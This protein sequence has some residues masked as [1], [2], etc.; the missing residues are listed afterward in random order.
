MA[1]GFGRD[2]TP[3][4]GRPASTNFGGG[5]N[6]GGGGARSTT[7]SRSSPSPTAAGRQGLSGVNPGQRSSA[8]TATG[9]Q[10]LGGLNAGQRSRADLSSPSRGLRAGPGGAGGVRNPV[11]G[12][13]RVS[14]TVQGRTSPRGQ[15][16]PHGEF[17]RPDQMPGYQRASFT[18]PSQRA[19]AQLMERGWNR[20]TAAGIVGNFQVE[21][22]GLNPLAV[23]DYDK[24]TG[25]YTA[26]GIGQWRGAR[27]DA[28]ER[29]FGPFGD[30]DA[31]GK[32]RM[33]PSLEAQLD[34]ADRELKGRASY[35]D[36][37]ARKAGENILG[38]SSMSA[39][40]V[41]REIARNYERPSDQAY[42]NSIG[43]RT[44]NA[45]NIMGMDW[46]GERPTSVASVS[47]D[48]IQDRYGFDDETS[49]PGGFSP[50]STTPSRSRSPAPVVAAAKDQER[51]AP[52]VRALG[53][54]Q[55]ITPEA[56]RQFSEFGAARRTAVAQAP[57]K[58][59]A[60]LAQE[61]SVGNPAYDRA[62]PDTLRRTISPRMATMMQSALNV[63]QP[64]GGFNTP[65]A[66]LDH[67]PQEGELRDYDGA[68]IKSVES[69]PDEPAPPGGLASV[70][71]VTLN[72]DNWKK[73]LSRLSGYPSFMMPSSVTES[74]LQDAGV[75]GVV[76]G[77]NRVS[78]YAGRPAG[79]VRVSL[80]DPDLGRVMGG[81]DDIDVGTDDESPRP[82]STPKDDYRDFPAPP[83]EATAESEYYGDPRD[84]VP[85]PA[86]PA[87]RA[88]SSDRFASDNLNDRGSRAFERRVGGD[89]GSATGSADVDRLISTAQPVPMYAP[90]EESPLERY[91]RE[92]QPRILADLLHGRG[93]GMSAPGGMSYA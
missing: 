69:L 72:Y 16:G 38:S 7:T 71:D 36:V 84:A 9:R 17:S 29:E 86:P 53:M 47:R 90:Y 13:Q 74:Q 24:A 82:G 70:P 81:L 11:G 34:F 43:R 23:G 93:Y 92:A 18:D 85:A 50:P 62:V 78:P 37:G 10:G 83:A 19:V 63:P 1:L 32:P 77:I 54:G 58:D 55:G 89:Y 52:E 3:S 67:L 6:T 73:E 35:A 42:A 21:S 51:I 25:R 59:Q 56:A 91:W 46:G 28:L 14:G 57:A 79:G 31:Q 39:T 76:T 65:Y 20:P 27:L 49:P 68:V 60:R 88:R 33:G 30:F 26:F 45:A 8:P 75:P 4:S 2:D 22:P 41:A 87:A 61:E 66:D 5:T 48:K 40:D 80:N 64:P 15:L 12:Q 44:R